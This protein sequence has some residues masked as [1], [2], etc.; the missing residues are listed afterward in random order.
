VNRR[1]PTLLVLAL[2]L[3][4]VL[5]VGPFLVPI[6]P[7]RGV[8]APEELAAEDSLFVTVNQLRVHARS[9]G[10]GDTLLLLLHG[11]GASAFS[12]REVIAPL[13]RYGRV[14]AFDRPGFGLTQR[15]LPGEWQGEISPYSTQGE[16]ELT[17]ALI[18]SLEPR[19]LVLVGNSAGGA[20]AMSVA[21]QIPERVRGLILVSPAVYQEGQ[22]A[23]WLRWLAKTPQMRRLG[24]LLVRLLVGQLERALP[25]AWHDPDRVTPDVLS[26][27]KQPL[28]VEHWDQAFW[29]YLT[30][31]RTVD[32]ESDLARLTM[33]VLVI[34]GDDD[35][36]VPTSQSIRV[37]GELLKAELVVI[38]DCGHV[39]MDECPQEFMDASHAFLSRILTDQA[40]Y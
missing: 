28:Q 40:T 32:L 25:T 21:L 33:P 30:A 9:A 22:R 35:T 36:W 15:P 7:L 13:A 23:S 31:D 29:T 14:V 10:E 17:L 8:F 37:A 4:F 18:E 38:P 12:F 24:P 6:P 26:G 3:L 34:T 2:T 1:K 20:L 39:A 16:L 27:Y 11:F 5:V 19:D